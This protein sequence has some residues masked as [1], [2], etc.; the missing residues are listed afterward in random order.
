MNAKW[1]DN[2]EGMTA[3]QIFKNT[4]NARLIRE[5]QARSRGVTVARLDELDRSEDIARGQIGHDD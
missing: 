4:H 1:T 2:R 3:L 5:H